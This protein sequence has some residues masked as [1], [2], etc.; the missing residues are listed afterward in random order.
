MSQQGVDNLKTFVLDQLIEKV[1]DETIDAATERDKSILSPQ[2]VTNDY[3]AYHTWDGKDKAKVVIRAI[4]GPIM[5]LYR[6]RVDATTRKRPQN[7]YQKMLREY[8]QRV[9]DLGERRAKRKRWVKPVYK[10]VDGKKVK[11]RRGYYAKIPQEQFARRAEAYGRQRIKPPSTEVQVRAHYQHYW[12]KRNIRQANGQIKCFYK[13]PSFM[14]R[15]NV[16]ESFFTKLADYAEY[17]SNVK[18][19]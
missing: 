1:A 5:G 8:E 19:I 10:V 7:Q 16:K 3:Q 18:A 4:H 2:R 9:R 14:V 17:F 15:D 12:N 6:K 11:V 13:L